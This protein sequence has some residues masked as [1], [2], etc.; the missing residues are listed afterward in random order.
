MNLTDTDLINKAQSGDES[1]FNE[2]VCR[3]DRSVLSIALKYVNDRDDA[4]D[5]Y[6]EVFLRVFRGLKKFQFKSEFSTWLYRITTNVC[7]TFIRSGKKHTMMRIDNDMETDYV[8]NITGADSES[9]S[10]ESFLLRNEITDNVNEALE[11]LSPKQKM[12]FI[13]KH[14]EGYKIREIS[15]M[16]NSSEGTIKKYLFEANHKLRVHLSELY[17]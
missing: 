4:K 5:I 10:P 15:E 3:Y 13:L 17:V 14:Y 6:Q 2:L 1:A 11:K 7:L 9:N 12:I 8:D 16:L